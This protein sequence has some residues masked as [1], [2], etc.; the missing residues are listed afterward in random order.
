MIQ[1][2]IDLFWE[3]HLI[4]E[5]QVS[6]LPQQNTLQIIGKSREIDNSPVI[7]GYS[8]LDQKECESSVLLPLFHLDNLIPVETPHLE[9][10]VKVPDRERHEVLVSNAA[11]KYERVGV[12]CNDI[13]SE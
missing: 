12:M 2:K 4:V 1:K 11:L 6:S 8:I 7:W 3:L 10:P 13:Q 5:G 9:L